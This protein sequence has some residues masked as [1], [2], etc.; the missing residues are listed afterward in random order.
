MEWSN[1]MTVANY[2]SLVQQTFCDNAIRSVVMIDDDFLT[3][4]ESIQAL[5]RE[6]QLD[7]KKLTHQKGPLHLKVFSKQKI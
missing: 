1:N 3:Y 7:A 4:S 6:I 2:N 5:N